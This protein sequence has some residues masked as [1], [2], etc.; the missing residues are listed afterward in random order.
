MFGVERAFPFLDRELLAFLMNVPGEMQSWKGIP[1]AFL[2][3]GT[4]RALPEGI[5]RR[6]DKADF[7]EWINAGL[8]LEFPELVRLLR[9]V[10]AVVRRGYVNDNVVEEEIG[11]WEGRA[12]GSNCLMSWGLRDLLGLEFWLQHFFGEEP[13]GAGRGAIYG[14]GTSYFGSKVLAHASAR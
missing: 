7:T 4:A 3:E 11:R 8:R 6:R 13:G 12:Q 14:T 1:K 10:G 2:R 9:S 5:A